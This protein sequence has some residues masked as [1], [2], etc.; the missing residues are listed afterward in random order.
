MYIPEKLKCVEY[1]SDVIIKLLKL[2]A[3]L[4]ERLSKGMNELED[5]SDIDLDE[6]EDEFNI[7]LNEVLSG[8]IGRTNW[9]N[10]LH[11]GILFNNK[12]YLVDEFNLE[13]L[14]DLR[15]DGNY[16]I[17]FKSINTLLDIAKDQSRSLIGL[18]SEG[19]LVYH[20]YQ[21]RIE[22]GEY[23][24]KINCP[25]CNCT[26]S[27]GSIDGVREE[28][29]GCN[30]HALLSYDYDFIT[31]VGLVRAL[32]ELKLATIEN[33]QLIIYN[34]WCKTIVE[35]IDDILDWLEDYIYEASKHV[36]TGDDNDPSDMFSKLRGLIGQLSE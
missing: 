26:I 22:K 10:I 31:C 13:E 5:E 35:D 36:D 32:L 29:C 1:D 34:D 6:L 33:D 25:L 9:I 4:N 11:S 21:F 17:L 16:D 19:E 27:L 20:R 12:L 18:G 2:K 23:G 30:S 8:E 14:M 24:P 7:D 15:W 28:Y 3:E